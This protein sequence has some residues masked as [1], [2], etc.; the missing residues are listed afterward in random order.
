MWLCG[1]PD[2]TV[3]GGTP[4]VKRLSATGKQGQQREQSDICPVKKRPSMRLSKYE[5]E[6]TLERQLLRPLLSELVTDAHFS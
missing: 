4:R 2:P 6:H 1:V 3:F 5:S